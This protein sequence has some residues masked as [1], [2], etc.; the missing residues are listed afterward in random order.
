[1]STVVTSPSTQGS[2][3]IVHSVPQESKGEGKSVGMSVGT[4]HHDHED[5]LI[6]SSFP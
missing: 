3:D 5:N 2:I 4:H 1:M 6:T